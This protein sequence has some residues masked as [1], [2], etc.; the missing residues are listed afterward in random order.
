VTLRHITAEATDPAQLEACGVASADSVV[1]V[2]HGEGSSDQDDSS[3]LLRLQALEEALRQSGLSLSGGD[4]PALIGA[5]S[6]PRM[7]ALIGQRYPSAASDL[8]LPRELASGTLVQFATQPELRAVYGE[9]L[10]ARGN[11][12]LLKPPELYVQPG[13]SVSFATLYAR[14]RA[15]GEV[16]LGV[17]KAGAEFP[18]LNPEQKA[19]LR[20]SPGDQL[21]VIGD[22]F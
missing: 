7:E 10:G 5:L 17:L 22:D 8:V 20:L 21:V 13:E 15:R 6:D 2:Q 16:A 3:A 4:G 19:E 1:M 11:E 12:V 14:A 9:L 18:E